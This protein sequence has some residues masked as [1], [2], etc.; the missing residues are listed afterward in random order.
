MEKKYLNSISKIGI[1]LVLLVAFCSGCKDD[2]FNKQPLDVVSDQTFWKTESDAKLALTGCYSVPYS[3][4]PHDFL[5]GFG[6]FLLDCSAGNGSDKEFDAD[7]ITNGILNSSYKVT[8]EYWK[9]SYTKIAT[10]NNFL[11]HIENINMDETKKGIMIA[12]VRTIRAYIYFNLAFYWGDV[13]LVQHVLTIEEANNVTRTPKANVWAFV[14]KELRECYPVLPVT[15]PNNENGHITSG[16]A[17]AILGRLQMAEKKWNDAADS[18]RKII[19][20]KCYLI[21]PQYRELFWE[22]KELSAE[23]ILSTQYLDNVY[24]TIFPQLMYPVMIGG[25]HQYSP[26]NELVKEYECIDGKTI[27]ESPLFDPSNPYNNR[28]PRMDYSILIS[29]R[30]NV[31]GNIYISRPGT[32]SPDRL[33]TYSAWTGYGINK[34][35]DETF[36][37]NKRQY[38]GNWIIIR[39]AEVLISYLESKLESGATI[40]QALLDQTINLVRKRKAVNMPPV[41]ITDP[42]K[43]RQIVRRERRVEFAFE[44]L[45]YYD[46]LRWGIAGNELNYQFTGMKL[47][48]DPANYTAYRV[49]NEGYFIHI[50]RNFKSGVNELWPIP[51]SEMD[52]NK[53]MTQNLGY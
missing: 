27:K 39:Y 52:I 12:E 19:D 47:T 37:G 48:N 36:S 1:I 21:D 25:F 20:Y 10:C 31:S 30:S 46:I 26:Y 29:D 3:P 45:R 6:I 7:N 35:I 8:Q 28:D 23:I 53:N 16:A 41:T 32:N 2:F 24:G 38:G 15:R 9:N 44:G 22:G 34:F 42:D 5:S 18:Y 49:D 51:Q 14:E 13:P 4:R 17:L 11:D 43:L 33:G 50:K 40:D